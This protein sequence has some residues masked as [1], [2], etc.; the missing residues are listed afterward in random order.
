MHNFKISSGKFG[1]YETIIMSDSKTNESIEFT[2]YGCTIIRF[3]HIV[4]GESFNIIDGFESP[5]ELT[6]AKGARC[7]IMTPFANRIP[8]G[9]YS[10][11]GNEYQLKPIHPR[12]QVMHG[13]TSYKIFKV[14]Y[15]KSDDYK[16]EVHLSTEIKKEEFEGYPF[17]VRV[18]IYFTL[19][20]NK[21]SIKVEGENI[22]NSSAPFWCGWHPYFKTSDN[23][24]EHLIVT[25][26]AD[27]IILMDDKLIPIKG[28]GAYSNLKNHPEKDFRENLLE[29]KRIVNGRKFDVCYAALQRDENG[30]S[31]TSI[32]DKVK[33]FGITLFQKGGYVLMFS[34]DSLTR[35]KRQS[36]AMEPM[37]FL[38]DSYNRK[39]FEKDIKVNPGEKK[40]F[41]FG[42]LLKP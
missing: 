28:E 4:D 38:T 33:D 40:S 22:G 37:Q 12:T 39:E 5:E 26:N 15:S 14:N 9:K 13:F 21:L 17:D 23:G 2:L 42:V 8:D 29:Y 24:I 18:N 25:I 1:P 41:E 27:E 20:D 31:Y 3:N 32:Y 35:G 34:G 10:F 7:W 36:L 11:D 30:Y 6:A 16:A 19:E